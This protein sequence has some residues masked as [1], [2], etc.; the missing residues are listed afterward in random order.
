MATYSVQQ[1]HES[2]QIKRPKCC[3]TDFLYKLQCYVIVLAMYMNCKV[4]ACM[5]IYIHAMVSM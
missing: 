3:Y 5:P 1:N 4:Y 2:V